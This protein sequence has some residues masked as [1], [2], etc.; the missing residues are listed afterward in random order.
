MEM[1]IYTMFTKRPRTLIFCFSFSKSLAIDAGGR[2]LYHISVHVSSKGDGRWKFSPEVKGLL[3]HNTMETK[4][5]FHLSWP[6]DLDVSNFKF[7]L[8]NL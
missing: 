3:E 5:T 2:G 8:E 7:H 1:V 6:F 4:L